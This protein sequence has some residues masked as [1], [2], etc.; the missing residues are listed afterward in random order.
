MEDCEDVGLEV[1]GGEWGEELQ[2][3]LVGRVVCN[4]RS[5]KSEDSRSVALS[6]I[7]S[8]WMT[9]RLTDGWESQWLTLVCRERTRT[10]ATSAGPLFQVQPRTIE[11]GRVCDLPSHVAIFENFMCYAV[12]RL[13]CD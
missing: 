11:E 7:N 3:S 6:A 5:A 13:H 2:V 8:R 4:G 9:E 12:C 1:H 10:R